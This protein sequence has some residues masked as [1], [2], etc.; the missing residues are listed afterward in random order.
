MANDNTTQYS[1]WAPY[2]F[3]PFADKPIFRYESMAELPPHNAVDPQLLTGEIHIGIRAETPIF[4]GKSADKGEKEHFFRNIA[5]ELAIPGSTLRGLVRENMQIL[6]LGLIQPGVDLD[7][8]QIYFREMASK[9]NGV[10]AKVRNAYTEILDIKSVRTKKGGSVSMPQNVKA[11]YLCRENG[12]YLIYPVSDPV[13]IARDNK[14]VRPFSRSPGNPR[15]EPPHTVDVAYTLDG[16]QVKTL[17]E[18]K[19]ADEGR[20]SMSRGVLLFTGKPVGKVPNHIYIFPAPDKTNTEPLTFENEEDILSYE[21]DLKA[22]ENGLKGSQKVKDTS[23]WALPKEGKQKPVF[24]VKF[25]GHLFFGMSRY[26]RVGYPYSLSHGLPAAHREAWANGAVPLDYPRA[27]LGFADR[28]GCAYR[29]RVSFGDMVAVG[30]PE[31]LPPTQLDLLEPKASYFPGYTVDGK[32]YTQ[33]DFRLRGYKQYWMKE[34]PNT[35][36]Y[37]DR[38]D[39]RSVMRPLPVGTEFTG[40]IRYKNLHPD[41]LGLLLLSLTPDPNAYQSIGRGKPYGYGRTKLRIT[42]LQT[43]DMSALYKSFHYTPTY[44][45]DTVGSAVNEYICSYTDRLVQTHGINLRETPIWTDLMKLRTTVCNKDAPVDYMTLEDY[46]DIRNPL[47]T[48]ENAPDAKK[49][50]ASSQPQAPS[51]A[52]NSAPRSIP[53]RLFSEIKANMILEG[54]VKNIQGYGVFVDIGVGCDGLVPIAHIANCFVKRME[55]HVKVGDIVRVK[56]LGISPDK[57]KPS[58]MNISLSIK[59]AN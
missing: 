37:P 54:R 23:F 17:Q 36:T 46:R 8:Y 13:R 24:Y 38:K 22:R 18:W 57:K 41:E 59:E 45:Q 6:G 47:P 40:V 14:L 31:P 9:A 33:E 39:F 10:K 25:N 5:G 11:G 52:G 2:N 19:P 1:A 7:D 49:P 42:A 3:I 56:V 43:Y 20:S 21:L 35:P 26:P 16:N 44:V 30:E 12:R 32:P 29:S 50:H 58:K 15:N 34:Q 4:V 28:S 48:V 55:D 27:I 53:K 51:P